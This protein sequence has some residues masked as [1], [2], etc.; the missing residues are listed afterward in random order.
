MEVLFTSYCLPLRARI[1]E[2]THILRILS[3]VFDVPK[4]TAKVGSFGPVSADFEFKSILLVKSSIG[5]S[6]IKSSLE[7]VLLYS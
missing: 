7:Q 1:R 6:S 4:P 2:T 5:F 3:H